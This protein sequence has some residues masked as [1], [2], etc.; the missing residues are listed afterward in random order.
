M[1]TL[2]LLGKSVKFGVLPQANWATPASASANYKIQNWDK[3][4]TIPD[5]DVFIDEA[6]ESGQSGIHKESE[7]FIADNISGLPKIPFAMRVA[8]ATFID[9][10][11]GAM[12]TVVEAAISPFEKTVT[13]GGL[14]S[15][16]DFKGDAGILSTIFID[17]GGTDD[18]IIL[19]NAIIENMLLTIDFN[20]RGQ[21]RNMQA[22]GNWVGNKMQFEQTLSGTPIVKPLAGYFNDTD[23]WGASTFTINSVDYSSECIRRFELEFASNVTSNCKTTG[24]KADQFDI[25]PVYIVRIFLDYSDVTEKI[26]KQYGE[27]GT[28]VITMKND[29]TVDTD[30]E[31]GVEIPHA[32]LISEPFEYSNEFLGV[33]VEA[34]IKSVAGATPFTVNFAEDIDGT[35]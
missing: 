30:G 24:G 3:D 10:L 6:N 13:C 35:F 2:K 11:A 21:L 25:A 19:E 15:P 34:E 16:I 4:V 31:F 1:S 27:G 29:V 17:P 9:Y 23:T 12:H 20:E 8:K 28:V 33:V 32:K 18:G 14:T 22:S 5:G 26:I 7:M